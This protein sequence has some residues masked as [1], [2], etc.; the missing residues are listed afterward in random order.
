MQRGADL[1]VTLGDGSF[2]AT[3]DYSF[4]VTTGADCDDQLATSG[5]QYETLPCTVT[6]DLTGSKQ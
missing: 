6:Y 1:D 3:L 4:S 5:G 2:T